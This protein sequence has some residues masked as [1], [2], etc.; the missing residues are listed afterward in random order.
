[1]TWWI[2]GGSAAVVLLLLA[3]RRAATRRPPAELPTEVSS[4]GDQN[5]PSTV[6]EL[7]HRTLT[8]RDHTANAITLLAGGSKAVSR[9]LLCLGFVLVVIVGMVLG[10][11]WLLAPILGR[12]A[13]IGGGAVVVGSVVFWTSRSLW[14]RFSSRQQ[15]DSVH[16]VRQPPHGGSANPADDRYSGEYPRHGAAEAGTATPGPAVHR[17][18][19]AVDI[20]GFGAPERTLPHQLGARAA[21]YKVVEEALHAAAVPWRQCHIE[22]RGDAIFILVPPD[23]PKGPLVEDAPDALARAARAHNHTSHT[24]QRIRLR[25]A[26]HA[27]EVA[28]DDHGVTSTSVNTTF[29]LLDAPSLKQALTDSPGLVALIVS[30]WIFDEVVC[31]SAALDPATFRPITVAVKET[32]ATAWM[33]MPDQPYPIDLTI[34]DRT[35]VNAKQRRR[36]RGYYPL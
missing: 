19:I 15:S 32:D 29:R 6:L 36:H 35:T 12:G 13:A 2:I 34:L 1:M 20:E 26:I 10:L 33:A 5:A 8:N 30:Q 7:V 11:A 16:P 28:L 3:G 27:G 14:R 24:S 31:H 25:M 18:I 9:V 21:L 23:I 17:T 22:D 4:P